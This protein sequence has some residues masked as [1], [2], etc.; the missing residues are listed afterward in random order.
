MLG[1]IEKYKPN[2]TP[3]FPLSTNSIFLTSEAFQ[4]VNRANGLF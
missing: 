4:V 2:P 1:K 3:Q